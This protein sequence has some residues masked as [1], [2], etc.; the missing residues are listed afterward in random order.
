MVIKLYTGGVEEVGKWCNE[1]NPPL[2]QQEANSQEI[3]ASMC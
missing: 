2:S 3:G 1:Q